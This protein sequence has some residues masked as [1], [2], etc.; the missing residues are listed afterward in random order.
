M[1]IQAGKRCRICYRILILYNMVAVDFSIILKSSHTNYYSS[2][3][4]I[5]RMTK[6]DLI[7]S[8]ATVSDILV[9]C[10]T[11]RCS[12]L[13]LVGGT[14]PIAFN[15]AR[16]SFFSC[17]LREAVHWLPF[18]YI[19]NSCFSCIPHSLDKSYLPLYT[20]LSL[21]GQIMPVDLYAAHHQV[22]IAKVEFILLDIVF[23]RKQCQYLPLRS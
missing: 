1:I 20:M 5:V 19:N 10:F 12:A 11:S 2:P 22:W 3:I 14:G 6:L 8:S 4:E 15:R 7:Q 13:V 16:G 17:P 18:G 21:E 23:D 9:Y